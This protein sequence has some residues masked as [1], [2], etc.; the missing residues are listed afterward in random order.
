[1]RSAKGHSPA[2]IALTELEWVYA[3]GVYGRIK[4]DVDSMEKVDAENFEKNAAD[5]K[6]TLKQK[7]C[8]ATASA[9]VKLA[10]AMQSGD[11]AAVVRPCAATPTSAPQMAPIAPKERGG[12]TEGKRKSA[13][14]WPSVRSPKL[15]LLPQI[16]LPSSCCVRRR[17]TRRRSTM[18][19]VS[20]GHSP[21]C[22]PCLL[23]V[24]C[25][26]WC[27]RYLTNTLH[28]CRAALLLLMPGKLW[29][30]K[31]LFV[32]YWRK[33]NTHCLTKREHSLFVYF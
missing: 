18:V 6:V 23:H 1:V 29:L 26:V 27:S 33:E 15:T 14:V 12:E 16:R 2:G 8:K 3:Y 31:M 21:T 9:L 22:W 24:D 5:K 17:N 30:T 19:L 28:A 11:L 10:G 25:G 7:G 20:V 32:H 4:E 13:R